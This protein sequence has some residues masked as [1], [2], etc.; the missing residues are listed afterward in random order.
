LAWWVA[1]GWLDAAQSNPPAEGGG[2]AAQLHDE[3]GTDPE[4]WQCEARTQVRTKA[5]GAA[6]RP[7]L[8]LWFTP[9]ANEESTAQLVICVEVK[10]GTGPHTEQLLAYQQSLEDRGA[11]ESIV[12]L[13]APR[14]AY[15]EFDEQQIPD[16]VPRLT[17]QLTAS[18]IRRWP[19]D[20]PVTSFLVD[21]LCA[22][23]REEGL[24]DL[25]A[26]SPLHMV[27]ISEMEPTEQAVKT[28]CELASDYLSRH[29]GAPE[30]RAEGR[31]PRFGLGYWEVHRAAPHGEPAQSWDPA[32]WSWDLMRS[33][34]GVQES[35]GGVPVFMSGLTVDKGTPLATGEHGER[36]LKGLNAAF[37][38]PQ[39]KFRR[40]SDIRERIVRVAYPEEIL[41]GRS[42]Q[43][44]ADALGAWIRAG[45]K[46][47][48]AVG[49]P[50]ASIQS[51][52]HA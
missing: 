48:Y 46:A 50:G 33:D 37:E 45:Y 19:H 38:Y 52:V 35:R 24:M 3:L 43:A 29:W 11:T 44:Q 49:P 2:V 13:V 21:E 6:R 1:T 36:W 15:S 16:T 31:Q 25:E 20:D 47:L 9:L 51:D 18:R 40:V 14:E 8:E 5:G 27:V 22:Y 23:L 17:W 7:D 42:L 30:S 41:I 34:A 26:L 12:L 28:V 32:L 4:A 10:H 39:D